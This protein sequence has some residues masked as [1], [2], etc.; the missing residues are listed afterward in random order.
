M[1]VK[2]ATCMTS[3]IYTGTFFKFIFEI[4]TERVSW[5][6][7]ERGERELELTNCEITT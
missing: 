4:E 3:T 1:S 6:E 7:A 5:E 2:N